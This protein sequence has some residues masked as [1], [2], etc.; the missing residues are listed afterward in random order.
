VEVESASV[1]ADADGATAYIP[2]SS[3]TSGFIKV[4]K[5]IPVT[6]NLLVT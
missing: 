3:L 5:S 4:G 6:T 2:V 1:G